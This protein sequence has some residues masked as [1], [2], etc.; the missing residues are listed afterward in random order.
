MVRVASLQKI[1]FDDLS[2]T[3]PLPMIWTFLEMD[4]AVIACNIPLLRPVASFLLPGTWM[5][6]SNDKSNSC[7]YGTSNAIS[8]DRSRRPNNSPYSQT[9][10][11]GGQPENRLSTNQRTMFGNRRSDEEADGHSGIELTRHAAPV[12]GIQVNIDFR[13]ESNV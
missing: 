6:S 1:V 8:N 7:P 12:D 3:L 5:G 10:V 13:V 11:D 9:F 2:F 4:L